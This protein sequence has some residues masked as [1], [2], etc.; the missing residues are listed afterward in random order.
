MVMQSDVQGW[1]GSLDAV[2]DRI[3][4]RF[5]RA[6]PRRRAGSYL[7]GLL[8]P[9]ERKNG[10]QLAEVANDATPDGMQ[11]FLSRAQWD[12]DAVRDGL[13]AYVT[14]HL[15]DAGAVLVLDETGLVKKGTKSAGVQRQYTGTAG[16]MEI[17]P[18]GRVS[19][20]RQPA[21]PRLD[22]SRA[23]CTQE[24]DR[25]RGPAQEGARARGDRVHDQ[26]E[27]GRTQQRFRAAAAVWKAGGGLAM[28]EQARAA[29]VPFSWVTGD[30]VYGADHAIWR[31]AE[32]HHRGYVL[33][34]TSAQGLGLRPIIAWIKT[35][36][37]PVWQPLSAGESANKGPRFYDWACLPYSG[38]ALGIQ[39]ALLIRH[40][41]ANAGLLIAKR[42]P[43][44]PAFM[45]A[46]FSFPPLVRRVAD[47][48]AGFALFNLI[49]L[50]PYVGLLPTLPA[51]LR[52]T[53]GGGAREWPFGMIAVCVLYASFVVLSHM[54]F[55]PA[56]YKA[57]RWL[58]PIALRA[59]VMAKPG[60]TE[61]THTATV[62]TLCL[63]VPV[64]TLYG[65]YQFIFAPQWDMY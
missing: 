3:A 20:L 61:A 4:P 35:L 53:L 2:L 46:V 25:G 8:A 29:S 27:A 30:S 64:L 18:D 50:T 43:L 59:F 32:Q 1:A 23:L 14:E 31:W 6:E 7:R 16:R 57:T 60:D 28:L 13:Q 52:W 34:V 48:Q 45:L 12:A 36:P 15:G 22:R 56:I 26:A 37:R 54:A 65:I 44:Y 62:R 5:G 40:L 47:Y 49:L 24:L 33:A 38:A 42:Q 63:V 55:V 11:D 39:C 17:Q 10:W 9:V 19:R 51:L 21:W 58:L 41:V